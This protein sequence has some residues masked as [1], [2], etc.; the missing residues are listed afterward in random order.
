MSKFVNHQE[1][2]KVAAANAKPSPRQLFG[3]AQ[4]K[5]QRVFN[6]DLEIDIND[7]SSN[8]ERIAVSLDRIADALD[9]MAP[10]QEGGE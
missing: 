7:M 2:M 9:R 6:S 8:L 1:M 10:A 4:A 3:N 5:P